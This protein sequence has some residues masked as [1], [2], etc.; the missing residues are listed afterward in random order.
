TAV[1]NRQEPYVR[2][3]VTFH[4]HPDCQQDTDLGHD[5]L[6]WVEDAARQKIEQ[7]PAAAQITLH[8]SAL[9]TEVDMAAHL[10]A[11]GLELKRHFVMM[12]IDMKTAPT[13]PT[14]PDGLSITTLAET[15]DLAAIMRATIDSFRDHYGFVETPFEEEYEDWLDWIKMLKAQGDFDPALWFVLTDTEPQAGERVAGLAVCLP[16]LI[17]DPDL[18]YIEILGIRRPWRR[19]GL[20]LTLLLHILAAFWARG[21]KKVALHVDASSLTGATRLYEKAGMRVVRQSDSYQL[22]LRDGVDLSTQTLTQ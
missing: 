8:I 20:A 1:W 22:V 16:R 11:Y 15:D 7:A 17:E 2:N 6:T 14:L 19:R 18:G 9:N 10:T 4:I 5:L 3:Y 13:V 21:N 12:Q